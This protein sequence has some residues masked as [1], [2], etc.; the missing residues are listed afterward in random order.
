[1][2]IFVG[3]SSRETTNELY[4]RIAEE[5][6]H[7][8]VKGKHNL[9]FGGNDVGLMGRVYS[10]VAKSNESKV[11]ISTAK[12]YAYHLP[13]LSYSEAHVYDTVNERKNGF[14][15]LSDI[16][17]FIPGGIGT[18]DELFNAIETKRAKE[19]NAPIIIVNGNDFFRHFVNTLNQM[20]DE[21]MADAT[22]RELYFIANTLEEA[23]EHLS[24]LTRS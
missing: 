1:M 18:M 10:V 16:L 19:H 13:N 7:F 3:C 21:C 15:K 2:N 9:V 8:I 22:T 14:W 12:P 23:L 6:G 11:L 24:G 5:I 20:Y 4:N 17:V